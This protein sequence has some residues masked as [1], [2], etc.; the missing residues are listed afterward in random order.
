VWQAPATLPAPVT[1]TL[2][3]TVIERYSF[4]NP[5]GGDLPRENRTSASVSVDVNDS[6]AELTFLSLTFLEDFS[7]SR[8]S[9]ATCVRNFSD[10]CRGKQSELNDIMAN[11][12][13]FE[14]LDATYRVNTITF[15]GPNRAE[16]RAPCEFQSRRKSTG[17]IEVATGTCVLT[18]VY[19]NKRWF[20]C[21]S[22]FTTSTSLWFIF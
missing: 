4:P 6:I 14:I 8:V 22:R 2:T 7:D 3:L 13:T 5:D 21:E 17:Q 10:N 15:D 9:P 1:Y 19:E 12:A 11:R 20:L 16:V 18:G